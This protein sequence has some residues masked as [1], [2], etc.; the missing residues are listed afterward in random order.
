MVMIFDVSINNLLLIG[1]FSLIISIL[2]QI[3]FKFMV[4][5]KKLKEIKDE[6]NLLKKELKNISF[7]HPDYAKKQ[8]QMVNKSLEISRLSMKPS[9]VT[10]I[11]FWIVFAYMS[12]LFKDV[13]VVLNWGFKLP[14]FGVG[15]GWLGTYIFFSLIFG[16][17]TRKLF[18]KYWW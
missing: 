8:K 17:S 4:D 7:T 12:K 2:N 9:F 3:V 11:P 18:E 16:M 6:V 13:G 10:L 14:L 15:F 1:V 5:T